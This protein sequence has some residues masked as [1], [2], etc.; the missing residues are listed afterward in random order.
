[1]T[2]GTA[3]L[4]ERWGWATHWTELLGQNE[5]WLNADR[6]ILRLDD[7]EPDYCGRVRSF[8]LRQAAAAHAN[9]LYQMTL[10]SEPSG[11]MA[12]DAFNSEFDRLTEEGANPQAWMA[13]QELMIALKYRSEGLP[14]RP[15][16]CHCGYPFEGDDG[17]VWDHGAC[18]PG[19]IVD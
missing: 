17:L 13:Q 16:T 19:V 15:T 14:A 10:G 9:L 12:Q 7:M 18:S 4:A 5:V 2:T 11:E 3:A 6:Q 1:M 8:C